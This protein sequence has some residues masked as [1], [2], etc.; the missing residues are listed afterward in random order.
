M[1]VLQRQSNLLLKPESAP[2][3]LKQQRQADLT[4]KLHENT[5][6]QQS[7]QVSM[8]LEKQNLVMMDRF[9]NRKVRNGS[10]ED[11]GKNQKKMRF[12]MAV[13]KRNS[14]EGESDRSGGHRVEKQAEKFEMELEK[15][16]EESVMEKIIRSKEIKKRYHEAINDVGKDNTPLMSQLIKELEKNMEAELLALEKDLETRRKEMIQSLKQSLSPY[17]S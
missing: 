13:H 6:K 5:S 17:K 1:A 8:N 12:S 2:N 16:M 7:R 14:S 11:R 3:D 4:I 15:I 10:V 9:K